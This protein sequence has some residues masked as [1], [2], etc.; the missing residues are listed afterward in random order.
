MRLQKQNT[1]YAFVPFIHRS[2]GCI[3]FKI[4]LK[5]NTLSFPKFKLKNKIQTK[6][7][8]NIR[9]DKI[10][11][12]LKLMDTRLSHKPYLMTL[13]ARGLPNN[14]KEMQQIFILHADKI[15]VDK[16]NT[17]ADYVWIDLDTCLKNEQISWQDRELIEIYLDN[18]IARFDFY[19]T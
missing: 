15:Y 5:D 8:T 9:L 14:T 3:L 2:D 18:S 10:D 4:N 1:I 19:N 11:E 16:E 6:K 13:A 12:L 7:D 17:F